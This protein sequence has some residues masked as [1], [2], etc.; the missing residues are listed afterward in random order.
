MSAIQNEKQQTSALERDQQV[1][2]TATDA[3]SKKA[4]EVGIDAGLTGGKAIVI[5]AASDP[6]RVDASPMP[7][8]IVGG[9]L[10]FVIGLVVSVA[11]DRRRTAQ[12]AQTPRVAVANA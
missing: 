3:L 8:A 7:F 5:A 10:G 6:V 4:A 11:R 9:I 1:A 2:S 12:A